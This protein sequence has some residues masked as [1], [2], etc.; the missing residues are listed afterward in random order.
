MDG[1]PR[2]SSFRRKGSIDWFSTLGFVIAIV[3]LSIFILGPILTVFVEAFKGETGWGF[4]NFLIG[5]PIA[6]VMTRY[7]FP[8]HRLFKVLLTLPLIMPPFIGAF[9]MVVMLG[10]NGILTNLLRDILG[11]SLA[12]GFVR[13]SLMS[14]VFVQT[15]HLWP[16]I[17]LNTS[18]SLSKIDPSLEES[19]RNLGAS[20]L[21]LFSRITFPL[22]LPGYVAGAFLTFVWSLSDIG[23]P[24]MLSFRNY[25]PSQ[26]FWELV[27]VQGVVE[28]ASVICV[29]LT[30]ISIASLILAN[31]YVGLK[32]YAAV[33][34]GAASSTIVK[35]AGRKLSLGIYTFILSVIILSTLPHIGTFI[36][37][38]AELPKYGSW[39]LQGLNMEGWM[40]VLGR[41]ETQHLVINSL[42]YASLAAIIDIVLGALIGFILVRKEFAGKGALDVISAMPLAVPGVVI[43][44]GYLFLF[45]TRLPGSTFRL[46]SFWFILV[47]AYSMRRLPYS[48]RSSHAVLQQIH[49][50]LEEAAQ[51]LGATRLRTLVKI[52]VPLMSVG[53]IAGGTLSFITA[54][55]EVSTSLMV[56]P[57]HGPLGVHARPITLGIYTE[58]QR[59]AGGYAAAGALGVIQIVTAALCFYLANRVVGE[60]GELTIGA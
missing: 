58:I 17:Y 3:L 34:V 60:G 45:S 49:V 44:L 23:S 36:V 12:E 21:Q 11:L 5:L 27:R 24:I 13:P 51:N 26:A 46:S 1:K 33:R 25:A 20:G 29:I 55:T 43:A 42:L 16:L 32:E 54:F 15:T 52:T 22:A 2:I 53:L 8:G 18:A 31:R 19:A 47:V 28:Y 59:G 9:S 30:V 50:S 39:A 6:Y 35:Q 7:R 38:F 56:Q 48:V 41:G 10:R 14:V 40:K 37:A 4:E 57:L